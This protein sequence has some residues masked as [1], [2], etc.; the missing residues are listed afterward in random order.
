[1]VLPRQGDHTQ[2]GQFVHGRRGPLRISRGVPD[3]QLDRPATDPT[4]VVDVA[5][6]QLEAG[7]QVPA[8]LDP[9]GPRQRN[10]STDPD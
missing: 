1:M 6:G 3:H 2:P 8:R 4:G 7:E 9:A 5:N 10:E